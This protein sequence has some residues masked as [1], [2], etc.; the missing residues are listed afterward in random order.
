MQV[1]SS[2]PLADARLPLAL[3]RSI[4]KNMGFQKSGSQS[5][6]VLLASGLDGMPS[7]AV[8]SGG[9]LIVAFLVSMTIGMLAIAVTNRG[10]L[11]PL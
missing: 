6:V 7:L 9:F 4:V 5:D 11:L 1:K 2:S 8:F 3:G 10:H